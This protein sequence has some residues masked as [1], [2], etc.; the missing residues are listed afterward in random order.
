MSRREE[1][2]A[3]RQRL[4]ELRRQREEKEKKFRERETP[5]GSAQSST[6]A[7]PSLTSP[8]SEQVSRE[9]IDNLV[10]QLVK[11]NNDNYKSIS[12]QTD[13]I[14]PLKSFN[15]GTQTMVLDDEDDQHKQPEEEPLS[16]IEEAED[17]TDAKEDLLIVDDEHLR[18]FFAKSFKILNRAIEEDDDILHSYTVH[19][20]SVAKED[21]PTYTLIR[22]WKQDS[23]IQCIDTSQYFPDLMAFAEE[24]SLMV[25]NIGYG[26]FESKF[27]AHTRIM[28]VQFSSF[29]SNFVFGSGYNGKI[30]SWDLESTSQQ[31]YLESQVTQ[32]T[33][34]YPVLAMDQVPDNNGLLITGSTDGKI[35]HWNPQI[36]AKPAQQPIKLEMPKSSAIRYDELTP[37]CFTHL[38]S[39]HGYLIVGSEDGNVYKMKRFD[40]KSKTDYI[41]KIFHGHMGPVT[42][43]EPSPA[44]SQLFV[45]SGMD[46]KVFLWDA[47][48]EE[49][50]LEIYKTN[51]IMACL[52]RPS[53]PTQIGYIYEDVLEIVDLSIDTV[54][55]ICRISTE[56]P[57]TT[58]N[59]TKDGER[60]V[61]GGSKG[62][63]YIYALDVP[64]KSDMAKF[65]KRFCPTG[66]I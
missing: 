38:E 57:L 7:S 33:H 40:Q 35:I 1:I 16:E 66:G 21:L 32:L 48:Q 41:E 63:I 29:R 2:E 10:N 52:W 20:S 8:T 22:S 18:S 34:S 19:K 62:G 12:V 13:L 5:D 45:T 54:T 51:A 42:S 17:V 53:F 31:P 65:K 37:T 50:L 24:K 39:E 64:T 28:K 25:Y 43:I 61:L 55:P 47:S 27:Q 49:P 56:E 14:S 9:S 60:V 59:F 11:E 36:L 58:F 6:L 15:K 3:K 4:A 23:M 44:L 26:K 46:W 30:F